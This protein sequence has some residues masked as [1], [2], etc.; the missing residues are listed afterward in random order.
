MG[1]FLSQELDCQEKAEEITVG[2]V[3]QLINNSF[4]S[5]LALF[6]IELIATEGMF[7]YMSTIIMRMIAGNFEYLDFALDWRWGSVSGEENGLYVG[8]FGG[9]RY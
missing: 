5:V 7:S 3:N 2:G 9:E 4:T 8:V 1:L 6:R